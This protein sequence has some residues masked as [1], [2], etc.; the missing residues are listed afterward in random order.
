MERTSARYSQVYS[1]S[2]NDYFHTKPG[3]RV[4]RG[5]IHMQHKFYFSFKISHFALDEFKVI[6]T[7]KQQ[8]KKTLQQRKEVAGL[9]SAHFNAIFH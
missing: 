8:F 9:D 5:R 3:V 7:L 1:I 2:E 6:I 4:S